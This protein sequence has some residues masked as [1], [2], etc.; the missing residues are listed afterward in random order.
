MGLPLARATYPSWPRSVL[1]GESNV[2]ARLYALR[3]WALPYWK[4]I[5]DDADQRSGR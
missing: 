5:P 1:L 3:K 2:I 4:R